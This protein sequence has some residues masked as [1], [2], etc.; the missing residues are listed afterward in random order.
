VKKKLQAH[1]LEFR[2]FNDEPALLWRAY[3]SLIR[4][5]LRY[6]ALSLPPFLV[7]T[8]PLAVLL[9]H[10][11]C[12]YRW[13]PL[14]VGQA[15]VVTIQMRRGLETLPVLPRIEDASGLVV[16]TP[17]VRVFDQRQISWRIRPLENISGPLTVRVQGEE[18]EKEI[19][20]GATLGPISPERSDSLFDLLLHPCEARLE[21]E[22]VAWVSVEYAGALVGPEGLRFHWLVWFS[23]IS[24]LTAWLLRKRFG[25]V[26]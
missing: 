21:S 23:I 25:T 10:L 1:L 17:A 22:V 16:E 4:L 2:L 26:L 14:P 11:D 5:N 7:A 12:F 3:R 18:I 6:L 20:A 13:Q 8:V 19:R 9:T 24:L 15:T